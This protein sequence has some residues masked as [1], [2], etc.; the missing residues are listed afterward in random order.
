[1]SDLSKLRAELDASNDYNMEL[2]AERGVLGEAMD[3]AE[4]TEW[5]RGVIRKALKVIQAPLP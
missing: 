3:M 5:K 1:M 4:S 2:E